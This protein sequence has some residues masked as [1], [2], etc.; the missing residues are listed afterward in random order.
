MQFPDVSFVDMIPPFAGEMCLLIAVSLN[1][2]EH[3]TAKM[4]IAITQYL[5]LSFRR[6]RNLVTSTSDCYSR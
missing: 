2:V 3:F 1:A 4:L 5:T 6:R